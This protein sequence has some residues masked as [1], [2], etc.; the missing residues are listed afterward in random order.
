MEL[1]KLADV[2]VLHDAV[3]AYTA[4]SRPMT[5]MKA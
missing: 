2:R 3:A 1:E 4:A 5:T